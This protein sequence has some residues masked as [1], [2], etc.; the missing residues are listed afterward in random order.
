MQRKIPNGPKSP[1]LARR[2]SL[3]RRTAGKKRMDTIGTNLCVLACVGSI[4]EM[5]CSSPITPEISVTCTTSTA[6][7]R[8]RKRRRNRKADEI[9]KDLI[10]NFG[11]KLK[12]SARRDPNKRDKFVLVAQ[13]GTGK[14]R[15]L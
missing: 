11:F 14:K 13:R 6:A 1:V 7:Q 4:V 12:T 15:K 5:A 2:T 9:W 10:D 8:L 3:R